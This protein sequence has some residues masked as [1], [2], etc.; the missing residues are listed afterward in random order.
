MMKE[1]F[2]AFN[3]AWRWVAVPFVLCLLA[4]LVY[5]IVNLFRD[6]DQEMREY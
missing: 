1:L 2:E 3:T 6:V 5:V 4:A